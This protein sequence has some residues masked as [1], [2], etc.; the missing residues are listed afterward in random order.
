MTERRAEIEYNMIFI[1]SYLG[2]QATLKECAHHAR[3]ELHKPALNA[4]IGGIFF[5]KPLF[6]ILNSISMCHQVRQV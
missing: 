2:L 3:T 1:Y 6:P 4:E 5:F